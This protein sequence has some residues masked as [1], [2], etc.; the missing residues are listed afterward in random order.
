M[1][2]IFVFGANEK[3]M[4]GGGAARAAVLHHGAIM[5]IGYGLQGESFGIPTMAG[6]ED[7]KENIDRFLEYARNHPTLEFQVTRIGC[8]IA[9]FKDEEIAPLFIAAPDNCLFDEAWKPFLG[10]DKRYWGTF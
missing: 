7:A 8:G 2:M 1:S 9:G 4:H 10:G 6:F 5:G 3:G